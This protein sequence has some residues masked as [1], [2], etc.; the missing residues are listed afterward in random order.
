[1][2]AKGEKN[3]YNKLDSTYPDVQHNLKLMK[4]FYLIAL[5]ICFNVSI[6]AQKIAN[7][8]DTTLLSPIEI[9]AVKASENAPFLKSNI[10]KKE[11]NKLNIGRDLP[12][13]INQ[14]PS[15]QVNSDAGNGIGYTGFRIRGTDASRINITIN[16]VPFNDPESQGTFLVNLPDIASSANGIQIQRGVGTST[17]GNGAFGGSVHINTNEIEKTKSLILSSSFGS[18]QTSKNSLIL[19][20]GLLKNHFLFSGRLSNIQSDG[21]VDRSNSRLQSFYT[22]AAYVDDKKSIRL[23]IFSGKERTNAAWFGIN[24]ATLDSNRTYNPAGNEKQGTPYENETDNYT[25]THYQLFFNNKINKNWSSNIAL[26]LIRGKG[27]FEQYKASA[28]LES[29]GL[30]NYI[31]GTDTTTQTDLI[32]QL[33][34]DNYFYGSNFYTQYKN[35]NTQL[36]IGGTFNNYDGKHYGIITKS[37]TQNA[38]PTNYKWYNLTANKKEAAIYTKWTQTIN[39]R[40]QTYADVQLRTV[41]YN[42]NGFRNNPSLFLKNNFVFFNP[43]AGITYNL[44]SW[45]FYLSYA[46]ANKEPN[47]DDFEANIKDAPKA[48]SLHDFELGVER[49]KT[50]YTWSCNLYYMLY[51]NQLILTGKVNDVYAYTRTNIPESFRAGIELE[52]KVKLSKLITC[53]GNATFSI[54]KVKNFTEYIDNYDTYTQETKFYN[55]TNL[56]FSPAITAAGN[57]TITPSKNLAIDLMSK[58]VSKQYLDNTANEN[59]KLNGYFLEDIKVSYDVELKNNKS[60]QIFLQ[61]NNIFSEKYVANGYTFSYIYGGAFST[62]NYYY[63]MATFNFMSGITIKL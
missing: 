24:Q 5:T 11:I 43:K 26:F 17:N 61:G 47:R 63:P 25:Q 60:I 4:N 6:Y 2:P 59:R 33:W 27:Y 28:S 55:T 35:D 7:P 42:I 21:Y 19:N 18:Y 36:S 14:T 30:P 32:R 57:I 16:G 40:F 9:N 3:L 22:S 8:K 62:E 34:L 15:I 58:Y 39:K 29:Y 12:F 23:N 54:N 45:K 49:N 56:S 48:E 52:G 31:N 13:I 38:I 44:K 1:M 20:S 10:S 41:Q 37:I 51:K 50:N 53:S 46:N